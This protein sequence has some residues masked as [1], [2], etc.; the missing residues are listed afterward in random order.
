MKNQILIGLFALMTFACQKVDDSELELSLIHQGNLFGAGEENIAEG[1][2]VIKKEK[3]WE[4]LMAKMD[5]VNPASNYFAET[6]IDFNNY[7]VIACFDQVQ[8]S[9]GYSIMID[10][11]EVK[12]KE[13][14]F[15]VVRN[16]DGPILALIIT[17]PYYIAKFP[18]TNKKISFTE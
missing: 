4:A 3:D 6:D 15:N 17:Q 1:N 18:K 16:D 13:V 8:N 14:V 10:D 11:T 7:M 2:M 9:A 12:K 5:A